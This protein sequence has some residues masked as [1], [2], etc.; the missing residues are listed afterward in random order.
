MK[1]KSRPP[2]TP[3]VYGEV[4]KS[5]NMP[6]MLW[7]QIATRLALYAPPLSFVDWSRR[8]FQDEL[9]RPA[10]VLVDCA[11]PKEPRRDQN[12][13]HAQGSHT[14]KLLAALDRAY[15]RVAIEALGNDAD[16]QSL[17]TL[18]KLFAEVEE[19]LGKSETWTTRL[20]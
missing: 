13:K 19:I 7:K 5:I 1:R 20:Q 18:R 9:T 16:T 8:I 11:Q 2:Q 12:L 17:E 3:D 4:R 15:D 10:R 6:E 14:A